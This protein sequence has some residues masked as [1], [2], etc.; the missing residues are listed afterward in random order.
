M[1]GKKD[2]PLL[3]EIQA[4][5]MDMR[6]ANAHPATLEQPKQH[7]SIESDLKKQAATPQKPLSASQ[8]VVPQN[9]QPESVTER[10]RGLGEHEY[11]H[12]PSQRPNEHVLLLLRRHWTVLAKHIFRLVVSL[13]VPPVVLSF[14]YIYVGFELDPTAVLYV[15][16]VLALSLYYLFAFLAYFHDFVDY[17]LDVW[18]VTDQRVV[19]VEQSGLFKRVTSELNILQI[20][21]VTSEISGKI[22]TFLDFG[23]VY[24]QTAGSEA[25]FTFEEVHHPSEVSKVIL[26]AHDRATKQQEIMRIQQRAQY[27]QQISA[28]QRMNGQVGVMNPQQ[29]GGTIHSSHMGA[30]ASAT[31]TYAPQPGQPLQQQTRVNQPVAQQP[32]TETPWQGQTPPQQ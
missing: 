4:A 26:Q 28:Q 5:E 13:I 7:H 19:S 31:H 1:F 10:R 20:Q 9:T 6:D 21:D 11:I 16:M 23:H 27:E 32:E 29:P 15:F 14:L 30:A 8:A 12:F 17:H 18:I 22:Q 3:D 2:N 25:R 24:I